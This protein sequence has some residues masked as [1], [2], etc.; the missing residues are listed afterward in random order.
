MKVIGKV[1]FACFG[2][3]AEVELVPPSKKEIRKLIKKDYS[4]D[5]L[6]KMSYRNALNMDYEPVAIVREE[7]KEKEK[8]QFEHPPKEKEEPKKESELEG[9]M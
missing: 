4:F 2:N 3:L 9:F 5:V 1:I 6:V 7:P 8:Y